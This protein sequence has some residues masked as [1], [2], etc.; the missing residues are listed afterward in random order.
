MA[1]CGSGLGGSLKPRSHLVRAD[2][3]NIKWMDLSQFTTSSRK[4]HF[5]ASNGIFIIL[6]FL[7][8]KFLG[9]KITSLLENQ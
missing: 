1:P 3:M 9:K 7:V 6:F 2:L 5:V 4:I 8:H